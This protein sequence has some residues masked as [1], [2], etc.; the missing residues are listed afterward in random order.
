MW[1]IYFYYFNHFICIQKGKRQVNK[2]TTCVNFKS[3]ITNIQ[4]NK[5]YLQSVTQIT[6]MI[7]LNND[8][9]YV[10]NFFISIILLF[11]GCDLCDT[12]TA[13]IIRSIN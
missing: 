8:I 4:K 2:R 5:Y 12:K 1:L 6:S 10:V 11:F 3:L 13:Q 7:I 9:F